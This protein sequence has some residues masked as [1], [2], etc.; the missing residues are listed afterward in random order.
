MQAGTNNKAAEIDAQSKQAALDWLKEQYAI[1]QG[2]YKP[3]LDASTAAVG[4]MS[5]QAAH[6]PDPMSLLGREGYQPSAAPQANPMTGRPMGA[7]AGPG[8]QPVST[9]MPV[10]GGHQLVTLKAPNGETRQFAAN[11]PK[12]A[13][14]LARG[15]QRVG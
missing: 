4:R 5:D 9:T 11:D 6:L 14:H 2:Q 13:R 1:A 12:V 15:A 3:F 7:L 8:G 10:G